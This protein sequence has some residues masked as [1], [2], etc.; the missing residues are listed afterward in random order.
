MK[1]RITLLL[2]ILSTS[3]MW[4][5]AP[6]SSSLLWRVES[7]E[8][9]TPSFLYGTIHLMCKD[10][11]QLDAPLQ[12]AFAEVDQLVLELDMDDPAM[13][14]TMQ[15]FMMMQD[16]LRIRDLME[17]EDFA[18]VNRFFK[19]SVGMGLGILGGFKPI[20]LQSLMY[21]VLL[22]CNPASY[23]EEFVRWAKK[24]EIEVLGLETIE[25]QMS[26]F[27]KIPYEKQAEWLVESV[28]DYANTKE[29]TD[30]MIAVYRTQD[31]EEIQSWMVESMDE[32]QE[33]STDL[34]DDRN[35]DWIPKMAKLMSEK[36][37]FFG[38]GAGHLGGEK[39]VIA[40]LRQAGYTVSPVLLQP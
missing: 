34:L 4:A 16:G 12:E 19:D 23:E 37:T 40:L 35:A 25:F 3:W 10:D 38:V 11:L 1:Y 8:G 27:D 7:P 36:P 6:T 28:E 39:G 14:G 2:L 26:V 5:Q 17:E 29:E 32:Y 30:R 21:P 22:G 18:L 9:G 13:M 20:I 33:F 31:L 15:K 24:A